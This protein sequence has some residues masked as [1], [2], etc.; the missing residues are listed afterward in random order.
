MSRTRDVASITSS[1]TS[2]IAHFSVFGDHFFVNLETKI[3]HIENNRLKSANMGYSETI[4]IVILL[5]GCE[6]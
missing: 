6:V 5:I 3:K 2:I 4:L 1:S